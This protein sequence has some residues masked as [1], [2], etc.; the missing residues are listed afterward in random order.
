MLTG[1]INLKG[2][3]IFCWHGLDIKKIDSVDK[4]KEMSA[5]GNSVCS[6][7]RQWSVKNCENGADCLKINKKWGEIIS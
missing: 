6:L 3:F 4:G 5:A 2:E 1:L 7:L